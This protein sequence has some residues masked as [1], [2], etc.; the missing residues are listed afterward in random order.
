VTNVRPVQALIDAALYD[1]HGHVQ[2]LREL[3]WDVALEVNAVPVPER[4]CFDYNV[5]TIIRLPRI[6]IEAKDPGRAA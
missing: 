3:G 5:S 4:D 2:W 6:L 1:L